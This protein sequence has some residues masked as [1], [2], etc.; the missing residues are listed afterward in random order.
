M[1][2]LISVGLGILD[3]ILHM[4]D[5]HIPLGSYHIRNLVNIRCKGTDDPY[6]GN[7]AEPFHHILDGYLIPILFQFLYNALSRLK[8]G[9]DM[10]NRV[11]V[12]TAYKFVIQYLD[13]SIN[14]F[15]C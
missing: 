8:P 9:F 1:I 10:F 15:Q 11:I 4:K 7:V 6:A 3:V 5:R 14:L 13:F 12:I 2:A